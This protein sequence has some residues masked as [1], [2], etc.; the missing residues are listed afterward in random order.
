M[1]KETTIFRGKYSYELS[2]VSEDVYLYSGHVNLCD[3]YEKCRVLI[4]KEKNLLCYYDVEKERM[5]V[6]KYDGEEDYKLDKEA[7]Q[8]L[9]DY[10]QW[11]NYIIYDHHYDWEESI[12][13]IKRGCVM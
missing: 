7:L 6:T 1:I 5:Y 11:D 3:D 12:L 4:V 8:E 13:C 10:V 2:G 9:T